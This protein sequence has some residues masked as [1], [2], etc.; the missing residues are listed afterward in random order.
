MHNHCC[1][2]PLGVPYKSC[3]GPEPD[4][5]LRV[6]G[7]RVVKPDGQ[8]RL[9]PLSDEPVR[10]RGIGDVERMRHEVPDDK[11]AL[12]MPTF[13]FSPEQVTAIVRYFASWDGQEYPYQ[14]A[15][16]NE[17]TAQNKLDVATKGLSDAKADLLVY[18]M[19]EQP[20]VEIARRLAAGKTVKDLRDL[21]GVAYLL[22]ASETPAPV[23]RDAQR[24]AD[25]IPRGSAL[26][27]PQGT[28][29]ARPH[30]RRRCG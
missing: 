2:A 4:G 5:A 20:I 15:R 7:A 19:G 22:G 17:L 28:E 10:V 9:R 13:N 30:L 23:S 1:S 27:A 25:G 6:R 16:A 12:R 24:S 11:L 26:D 3:P 21:R 29:S 18:G 8:V 14:A